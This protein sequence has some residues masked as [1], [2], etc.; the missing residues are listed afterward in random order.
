MKLFD[1][2]DLEIFN[3]LNKPRT[4]LQQKKLQVSK[5]KS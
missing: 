5:Y 4:K 2:W 1:I 3:F